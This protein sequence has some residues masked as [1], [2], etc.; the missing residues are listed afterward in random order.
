VPT[1]ARHRP[2][3]RGVGLPPARAADDRPGP[4]PA[5][6]PVRA[7]PAP[8]RCPGDAP[9]GAPALHRLLRRR[10]DR[11]V[12]ETP[13]IG[14]VFGYYTVSHQATL[15]LLGPGVFA[16]ADRW[17]DLAPPPLGARAGARG[18]GAGGRRP[19]QQ[20]PDLR[21]H[22]Q[23]AVQRRLGGAG[24]GS[25]CTATPFQATPEQGKPILEPVMPEMLVRL[26]ES[27]VWP[28]DKRQ[29]QPRRPVQRDIRG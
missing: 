5:R 8:L 24:R 17:R 6:H 1:S 28:V 9:R 10:A 13:S 16:Q 3:P 26:D 2:R 12:P 14:S 15:D 11:I 25:A 27:R 22:H 20:D 23:D 18:Q 29:D 4:R 7:Q 19:R 21:Q